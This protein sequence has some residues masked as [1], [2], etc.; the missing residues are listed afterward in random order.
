VRIPKA[1]IRTTWRADFL[2]ELSLALVVLAL[3]M[4]EAVFAAVSAGIL[5]AL[6]SLGLIFH[7]RLRVLRRELH[8]A[9]HLS[10]TRMLLG[11]N[12]QGELTIRNGSS[13]AAQILA[14]QPILEKALNF[15]LSSSFSGLL[16]PGATSASEFTITP[17]ARGRFQMSGFTL[18]LTDARR[19]FTG[20]ATYGQADWA[21][22]RPTTRRQ[23]ALTPLRLYGGSLDIFRKA[24]TG[25]DYAGIREYASGD[26]YHRVEWKATARLRTLM[27]KEFH[28]ESQTILQI[29]IDTGRTMRR[30]SYI[31][32]RLDEA[33]AVAELMTESAA[34]SR[35]PVGILV[36]DE[37]ELLKVMKPSIAVEQVPRLREL[38]LALQA[39][40]ES[41]EPPASLFPPRTF[42]ARSFMPNGWRVAAFIRLLR[43]R[44]GMAHRRT[45]ACKALTE[46]ARIDGSGT[47]VVLTNLETNT[48]A[49]LEAASTRQKR[50]VETVIAQIGAA[51]RLSDDLELAYAEYQRNNLILKQMERL[52]LAVF[53]LRPEKLVEA[54]AREISKPLA[55]TSVFHG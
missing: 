38:S 50:G 48:E 17:A 13:L 54:I 30:P 53:D 21:E 49:L 40:N 14:V 47:L 12:V 26:E 55:V 15:R 16:L 8:V 32:T 35:T 3:L 51:W 28:P 27:V 25:A 45:G 39:K 29:L 46:A 33:L 22:V 42:P 20:E 6:A 9:Q 37:N 24:P 4:R 2:V 34:A 7:R 11:D 31:G 10:K 52:G 43:A 18:T 41:G 1:A 5:L 36:Y 44:L 23:A 19:L